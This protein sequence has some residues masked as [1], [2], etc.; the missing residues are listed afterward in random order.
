MVP[1]LSVEKKNNSKDFAG[2]F[3]FSTQKFPP[4]PFPASKSGEKNH[5]T[6][7]HPASAFSREAQDIHAEWKNAPAFQVSVSG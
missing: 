4:T 2:F 7:H 6:K 3:R 1:L 5:T